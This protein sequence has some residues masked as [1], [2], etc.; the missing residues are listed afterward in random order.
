MRPT[1]KFHQSFSRI[2]SC[3][4]PIESDEEKASLFLGLDRLLRIKKYYLFSILLMQLFSASAQSPA[5][6][7]SSPLEEKGDLSQMMVEGIDVLL[8]REGE[9]VR[10]ERAGLWHRD[11]SSPEAFSRSIS[12]QRE[13]LSNRLGVIENRTDPFMEV[14]TG[15]RLQLFETETASIT[16]RAVRWK[17]FEDT[18]KGFSAEGLHLRPKGKILA[19][20]VFIPDAD[21]LPE[22]AAG[23]MGEG[24]AGYNVARKLAESG[25]EVLIPALVSRDD[26]FSGSQL[27]GR[28][29]NQPHREWI[30]RQG[31]VLGRH[32][33]GY[34]LQK[35]FAA[36]DWLSLQNRE[37]E[38]DLPIGVAGFGEGGMLALQAAALDTRISSTLVSGYFDTREKVW[39]EPIYRNVFGLLEYFGDAELAAM[40]WPRR[41]VLENSTFPVI[42][43]PPVASEGRS[44]AAP[45]QL[46]TPDRLTAQAEW[47]R[48]ES[49]VPRGK[50]NLLWHGTPNEVFSSA[51]LNDFAS[52]LKVQLSDKLTSAHPPV[53]MPDWPDPVARQERT[54]RDM[55]YQIQRT[56][57]LSERTRNTQFW[58]TL[59]EPGAD[60][61]KIKKEHRSQLWEVIGRLPD[62]SIAA[63][64]E[65]R[66]LEETEKWI[67]YEVKLDVWP[68]V[69][70]WGILL[71][72]KD[73]APG[74]QRAAVVCQHGL[75][76]TPMDVINTDKESDVYRPYQGFASALADREY[77]V[78]APQNPYIGEDSFRVLQRKANPLGLSLSRSLP[79]STSVSLNG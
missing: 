71:I 29:T 64:P 46:K 14:L 75:E 49:L 8:E 78:F 48:A 35:V 4:V 1:I 72:P 68:D 56:L 74:E 60:L 44:G 3:S 38:G 57:S 25:I 61:E 15:D 50:S 63:N 31:F 10:E 26:T 62:P 41:L 76:G 30:Y 13:I 42:S 32:V 43:G 33:I 24:D 77:V 53:E 37:K 21:M 45:G 59:K 67:S 28:F 19:R 70:T 54:V 79:D 69:F 40:A 22:V 34:E 18:F 12:D 65:S 58:Q 2:I 16:V 9:R 23:F 47:E 52:G 5:M 6:F 73:I 51:A 66:L 20:V 36:I 27:V 39:Q 55:E 11:F 7:K 17:V